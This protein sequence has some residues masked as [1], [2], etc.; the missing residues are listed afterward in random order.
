MAVLVCGP[1]LEHR[2]D[3]T[4]RQQTE[5][6]R[7]GQDVTDSGLVSTVGYSPLSRGQ[8]RGWQAK[9]TVKAQ[10]NTTKRSEYRI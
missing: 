9:E 2:T 8:G 6:D 5:R 1:T 3:K 7:A 4:D 10:P